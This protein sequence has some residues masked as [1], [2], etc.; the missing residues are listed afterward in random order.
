MSHN[1]KS[2]LTRTHISIADRFRLCEKMKEVLTKGGDGFWRY[3]AGYSDD[4]LAKEFDCTK[5]IIVGNRL[6]VFGKIAAPVNSTSVAALEERIVAIEEYLT[7][8][9]PG[10]NE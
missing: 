7:R 5:H 4:V 6:A 9:N 3:A 10:W 2:D 1:R 8:S